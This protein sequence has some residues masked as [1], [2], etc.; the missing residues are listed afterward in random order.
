MAT[1]TMYFPGGKYPAGYS[2]A[3]DGLTEN[4]MFGSLVE[5]DRATLVGTTSATLIRLKLINGLEL[6]ISGT[7]FSFDSDGATAGTITKFE[8]RQS[9]GT[10]LVQKLEVSNLSLVLF[11]DAAINLDP[12][13]M[14]A[15]LLRGSDTLNGSAGM[16]N[17]SGHAG[18][19]ILNGLGESD[20]I[21]GGEGRDTYDGG[22]G[23]D[24]LSFADAR[25]N[26]NAFRGIVL[27]AVAGTVTDPWGN[28]ETF[29]NFE[30]YRGSHFADKMTG[31]SLGEEFMGLGGR[32][33]INGGGGFDVVRYHRDSSHGGTRGVTVNLATGV[34]VDG[35]GRQDTLTSIEGV[36]GT[37]FADKLTGSNAANFLR[38]DGGNDTLAGGLGNDRLDGGSGKD[39]FIF[40]TTLNSATNVDVIEDFDPTADLIKLENSIFKA[41]GATGAL[42]STAF[43][44]NA[45]GL[46][47]NASHRIIYEK[48]TGELYYDADGTG[49]GSSVLFAK[50]GTNLALSYQDFLII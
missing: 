3:I 49:A 15:W 38:G 36:R 21:E 37:E 14:Q 46:A 43:A 22:E 26:A 44:A 11:E 19:D 48:D 5:L 23:Y 47:S 33:A 39:S 8:L 42:A 40:N 12:W 20:Y 1:F 41:F 4:V 18:N 35:F 24:Q 28:Q 29:K 34:A 10:S 30:S 7:G 2:P 32:D 9:N 17:L 31:S 50:I 25:G 13:Q 45:T 16:D 27:D 6:R